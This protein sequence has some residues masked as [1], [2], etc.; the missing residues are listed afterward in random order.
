MEACLAAMAIVAL[1]ATGW[2]NNWTLAV[3]DWFYQKPGEKSEDIVIVELDAATI[4]S[5]GPV[6]TWLRPEMANA[7]NILNN[8]DPTKR[9]AVIGIDCLFSGDNVEDPETDAR[10][11]AAA[12]QYGNVVI[13]SEA[14]MDD[15][16]DY[17]TIPKGLP[18]DPPFT[19]LAAA[20]D[21][22]LI[23][24]P[25]DPDGITRHDFLFVDVE[26]RGQMLSFGRTIY[27]KW[28]AAKGL[29]PNPPPTVGENGVFYLPF[30]VRTYRQNITFSDLLAG[31]ISPDVYAGKIVLIGVCAKGM[32]DDF[33]TALDHANSM[34]GIDIH[35]NA[36]QAFQTGFF[37]R[38]APKAPQLIWL[39]VMSFGLSFFFGRQRLSLIMGGWL[40]ISVGW[41]LSCHLLYAR[42]IMLNVLW[43]PLAASLLLVSAIALNYL[44]AQKDREEILTTFGRYV[45]PLVLEELLKNKAAAMDVGGKLREIAVLFVDIRGFTSMSEKLP[46][47]TVVAILNR[48]LTLT[49]ACIQRYHGTLDKFVGDCT[50][51]FWN[52]PLLQKE[53]VFL[54][55]RAALDMKEESARLNAEIV[56]RYGQ[57][58]AFGIGV[59]W[60]SAVVGNIG[61]QARMD[62]TAIGDTV[63]TAARLEEN[64]PGGTILIS[65]A[66]AD[67]LGDRAVVSPPP[68]AIK[69]KGKTAEFEILV[70]EALW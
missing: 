67:K 4:N 61:S 69:L 53:A 9:P 48:Y 45:D 22:G 25:D 44:R 36:I 21:T 3:S 38:E 5:L 2:L 1:V 57:S 58:I 41:L 66:V 68:K 15:V 13:A 46:P 16:T 49:T 63:N 40:G 50:M 30:S 33:L 55:C 59:H 51:A 19:A 34:Y 42:G 28:C 43:V 20:T 62:Y 54:A 64:A 26:G 17:E 18:W 14:I 12:G 11:A 23:N 29:V 6:Y 56:A 31:K 70:L 27:E 39:G 7:I 8:A 32:G 24:G 10:L 47:E 35:G 65:R 37:P 60:G 52:A